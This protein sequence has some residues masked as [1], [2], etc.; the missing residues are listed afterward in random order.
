MNSERELV[1]VD[2]FNENQ[3]L[4]EQ[5][6]ELSLEVESLRRQLAESMATKDVARF[7]SKRAVAGDRAGI[8]PVAPAVILEVNRDMKVAVVGGGSRAGM[9]SGM[10]FHVLRGEQMIGRLRLVDVRD[11]FAGGLIEEVEKSRFPEV[12]DRLVLSSSQDG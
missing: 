4:K 2:L 1:V 10:S 3:L 7:E 12:G 11:E 8:A 6:G 5:L 9:K